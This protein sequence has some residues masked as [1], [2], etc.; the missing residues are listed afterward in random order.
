M[1]LSRSYCRWYVAFTTTRNTSHGHCS[2]KCSIKTK[3]WVK[4][5]GI[6]NFK[7]GI[8][9]LKRHDGTVLLVELE[10]NRAETALITESLQGILQSLTLAPNMQDNNHNCFVLS[11][12]YN[13][14]HLTLGVANL[15]QKKTVNWRARKCH[16]MVAWLWEVTW[17]L[18]SGSFD[19]SCSIP[20]PT[21]PS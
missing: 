16:C 17:A 3:G 20:F 19:P 6:Y 2:Y 1:H 18:S 9:T 21:S 7:Y 12:F 15:S 10:T 11:C 14:F 5:G 13:A 4:E 8:W